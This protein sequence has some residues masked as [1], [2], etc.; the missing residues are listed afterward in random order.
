MNIINAKWQNRAGEIFW[1]CLGLLSLYNMFSLDS[2]SCSSKIL[3]GRSKF[4]L[5]HQKNKKIKK[6]LAVQYLFERFFNVQEKF[7]I[8]VHA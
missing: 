2:V 1:D 6:L 4:Y 3:N 7:N 8:P 5:F